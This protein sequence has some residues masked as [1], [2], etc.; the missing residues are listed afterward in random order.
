MPIR[1]DRYPVPSG[2]PVPRPV[3]GIPSNINVPRGP[4]A[5]AEVQMWQQFSETANVI[6]QAAIAREKL[7]DQN[8]LAQRY[9]SAVSEM[10]ES[11]SGLQQNTPL[12][13]RAPEAWTKTVEAISPKWYEGLRP[14]LKGHLQRELIQ[15]QLE[16]G[17][18]SR[19]LQNKF[20][21]DQADATVVMAQ[22]R[23]KEDASRLD[24]T[25]AAA[26]EDLVPQVDP[27]SGVIKPSRFSELLKGYVDL[28]RMGQKEAVVTLEKTLGDTAYSRAARLVADAPQRYLDLMKQEEAGKG[29]T[30]LNYLDSPKRTAFLVDATNKVKALQRDEEHDQ[31]RA[32]AETARAQ[33]EQ[34]K[35]FAGRVEKSYRD[36]TLTSAAI[37]DGIDLRLM[38]AQMARHYLDALESDTKEGTRLSDSGLLRRLNTEKMVTRD[39]MAFRA[40]VM[41]I[42]DSKLRMTDRL[43]IL[44]H[45]EAA[46]KAQQG[47]PLSMADKDTRA[48]QAYQEALRVSGPMAEF[49]H[50]PAQQVLEQALDELNRNAQAGYPTDPLDIYH[51][52][53]N[54]YMARIGAIAAPRLAEMLRSFRMKGYENVVQLNARRSTFKS[55]E[56][57]YAEVRRMRDYEDLQSQMQRFQDAGKMAQQKNTSEKQPAKKPGS[58]PPVSGPRK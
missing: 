47:V 25:D 29:S 45:V 28:G 40:E 6:G 32:R 57:F 31:D 54:E 16:Y 50:Q 3:G 55:E 8:T 10:D 21:I 56:D 36:N 23:F 7:A 1:F 48:K 37:R 43:A 15:K 14:E 20:L 42:P 58:T 22:N 35:I 27:V 38:D 9:M 12:H 53:K 19:Q 30:F 33:E 49:V 4:G 13:E 5:G 39:P 26:F 34:Q 44:G 17:L 2:V 18:K 24:K 52:K 41:A 11:F 51:T 46:A